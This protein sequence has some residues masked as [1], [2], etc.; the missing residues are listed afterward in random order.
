MSFAIALLGA[1]ATI[2]PP[3]VWSGLPGSTRPERI[4]LASLG[5]LSVLVVLAVF[6]ALSGPL[7]RALE[8]SDPTARIGAG[9]AL[10]AMGV[11]DVFARPAEI[12]PALEGTRA[13]LM[14]IAIP[15]LLA[16]G[17]VLL[18]ISAGADLGLAATTAVLALALAT[19]VALSG[20][21]APSGA[22]A[23]MVRAVHV[24]VAGAA[25]GVGVGLA[26]DGVF[27]I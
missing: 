18:A 22:R 13:A 25:I 10:V 14:P 26:V 5:A 21:S 27:D 7:L 12:Q 19:I 15:H 3:R 2:N 1:I 20:V 17:L 4:R 8:I 23:R 9:V 24:L 6:A 11:R 16:P